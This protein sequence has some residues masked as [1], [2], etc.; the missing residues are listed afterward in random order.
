MPRQ[1]TTR[2][3]FKLR[4]PGFFA[5]GELG[6]W[7]GVSRNSVAE[8]AERFGLRAIEGR[9]PEAEVYRKILGIEPRDDQDRDLLR[10]PLEGTGWLSRKTG[11]PASTVRA[12]VRKGTFAY[13]LGVQLSETSE[14]GA[15]PRSRRWIPC[16]IESLAEGMALPD[17][18]QV[19]RKTDERPVERSGNSGG[20]G[21]PNNVFAQIARGDA[22][23]APQ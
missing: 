4:A 14:G 7:L 1:K 12:K 17:F 3:E 18:V 21:R 10:R 19:A 8:I 5:P 11:V 9:Y 16:L 13:P 20:S 22:Q 15:E 2:E 23:G 6:T